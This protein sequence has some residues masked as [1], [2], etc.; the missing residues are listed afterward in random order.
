MG[1]NGD[2]ILGGFLVQRTYNPSQGDEHCLPQGSHQLIPKSYF[3]KEQRRSVR[4]GNY[5]T[6]QRIHDLMDNAETDVS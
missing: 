2:G 4:L 1:T 5:R 3:V 6:P